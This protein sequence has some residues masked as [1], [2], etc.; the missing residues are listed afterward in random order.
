MATP[1]ANFDDPTTPGGKKLWELA[2]KPLKNSFS[3]SKSGCALFKADL[4][5]R[6]KLCRWGDIIT[7]IVDGN[8]HNLVD[9][10]D[11]I[12]IEMVRNSIITRQAIITTGPGAAAAANPAA[13]PPVAARPAITQDEFEAATLQQFQSEMLH[14]VLSDSVTGDLE[15]HVAQ[16]ANQSRTQ[17]DG[18]LLLKLIQDKARGKAVKQKMDNVWEHIK[19][20]KLAHCKWNVTKFVEDLDASVEALRHNEVP[21]LEKDITKM[22]E[23]NFKLVKND[24]F[25]SLIMSEISDATRTGRDIDWEDFKDMAEAECQAI[26]R[27]VNGERKLQ[28]RN[29]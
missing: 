5:G 25:H 10:A 20:M 26:N 23:D 22:L 16:L 4:R 14:T 13:N 2:T 1:F 27:K 7:F 29:N 19:N 8:S 17:D 6:V 15:L 12:P 21:F 3:G 24:D 18:P 11:L 9:N 28:K